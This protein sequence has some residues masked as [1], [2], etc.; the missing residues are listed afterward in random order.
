MHL[1]VR[2]ERG[3]HDD[4]AAVE[5]PHD[6]AEIVLLSFSDSD[7]NTAASVWANGTSL[8]LVRLAQLQHPLSVDLYVERVIQHA[9]CVVLRLLGGMEYW[10]YGAEEIAATCRARG[11]R[12]AILP[13]CER[14][15]PALHALSTVPDTMWTTLRDLF[16]HGGPDNLRAALRIAA[17]EIETATPHPVPAAGAITLP[18]PRAGAIGASMGAGGDRGVSLAHDGRRH[19]A[20]HR[21]GRSAGRARHRRTGAVCLQPEGRRCRRRGGRGVARNTACGCAERHRV[22]RI[23]RHGIAAGCRRG[24]GAAT[25]AVPVPRTLR[26]R[27]MRGACRRPIWRCRWCCRNWTGGC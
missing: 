13:G 1:L 27:R 3:L 16:R 17:G 14:E 20:D 15:D 11:I 8:R 18:R 7:L 9:R 2:E 26:G 4:A 12:L 23:Q 22:F 5:L 6:P 10:R 24:A 21:P 25:G 19:G